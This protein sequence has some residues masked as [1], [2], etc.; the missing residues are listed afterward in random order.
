MARS[1]IC[2]KRETGGGE[3][4]IPQ[5][6]RWDNVFSKSTFHL[7]V[8]TGNADGEKSNGGEGVFKIMETRKPHRG[9][10]KGE[11]KVLSEGSGRSLASTATQDG[12]VKQINLPYGNSL[13]TKGAD[14]PPPCRPSL[15]SKR[16]RGSAFVCRLPG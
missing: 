13:Q 5:I 12:D 8:K 9:G 3:Q 2:R 11:K 16:E 4:N 10:K 1:S 6:M 15:E 7:W 14:I